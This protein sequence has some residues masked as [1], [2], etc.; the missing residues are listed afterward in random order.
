MFFANA[1]SSQYN[2]YF[3]LPLRSYRRALSSLETISDPC[4]LLS[5]EFCHIPFI[6]T[7]PYSAFRFLFDFYKAN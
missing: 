2:T 6:F 4:A 7:E 3:A 5:V 1:L